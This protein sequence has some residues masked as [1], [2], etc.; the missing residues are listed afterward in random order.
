MTSRTPNDQNSFM[1]PDWCRELV[2]LSDG[3]DP[4]AASD[5]PK[6]GPP[7]RH[8]GPARACAFIVPPSSGH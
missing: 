8:A 3:D 2:F 5:K 6:Q 4:K 1:P 7:A